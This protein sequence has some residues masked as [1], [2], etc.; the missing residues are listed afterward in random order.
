[1]KVLLS[2]TFALSAG[3]TLWVVYGSVAA[4]SGF[5]KPDSAE[6]LPEDLLDWVGCINQVGRVVYTSLAEKDSNIIFSPYALART[7]AVLYH[8]ASGQTKA[9]LRKFLSLNGGD[10]ALVRAETQLRALLKKRKRA[11]GGVNSWLVFLVLKGVPL[12]K[13]YMKTISRGYDA[14]IRVVDSFSEA[15]VWKEL[16]TWRNRRLDEEFARNFRIPES[17]FYGIGDIVAIIISATVFG[18]AWEC[19]FDE[20]KTAP[21]RFSLCT[22]ESVEV[23]FMNQTDSFKLIDAETMRLLELGLNQDFSFIIALP[24]SFGGLK[25]AEREFFRVGLASWVERLKKAPY[26]KVKVSLPKFKLFAVGFAESVLKD[27]GL[28]TLFDRDKCNLYR[29]IDLPPPLIRELRV[30]RF[31]HQS[32]VK[33]EERGVEAGEKWV[34]VVSIGA[35]EKAQGKEAV[36]R[37][38][39]PFLFAIVD[40]RTGL[41]L[42][43]GR[44]LDPTRGAA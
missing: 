4:D 44:L 27:R 21:G 7:L 20:G 38:D 10:S 34:V 19:L 25:N 16:N 29:M 24:K 42:F 35:R 22:G 3:I 5:E 26:R 32:F 33:V 43:Y 31:W 39:H 18:E 12:F 37:A 30:A 13:S 6:A 9:E 41:V 14:E 40:R 28:K 11:D 23:E 1:M 17:I 2:A 8:G 36:F 15:I